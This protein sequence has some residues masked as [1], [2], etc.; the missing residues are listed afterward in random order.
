MQNTSLKKSKCLVR[1]HW[2]CCFVSFSNLDKPRPASS[3][4]ITYC[5]ERKNYSS[6]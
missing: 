3:H 2:L 6:H 1:E 5:E 4:R